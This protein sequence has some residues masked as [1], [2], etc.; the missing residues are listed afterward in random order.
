[1]SACA[2]S[3]SYLQVHPLATAHV[4]LYSRAWLYASSSTSVRIRL[5][6]HLFDF[7]SLCLRA[8]LYVGLNIYERLHVF[9]DELLY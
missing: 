2:V 3:S 8:C 5:D 4:S 7:M 9:L 1:M 6:P